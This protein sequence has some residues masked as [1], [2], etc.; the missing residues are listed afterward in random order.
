MSSLAYLPSSPTL[1]NS[2]TRHTQMSSLLPA[3]TRPRDDLDSIYERYAQVA[4]LSKFAG[5]IGIAFSR[6]RS[7]GA[8]IRGT[9]GQS[10]GIVPWLRTLDAS[11]AAVNQGGRRKGA[12]CVY[13]E[14]WHPDVEEFLELR[15]NTGEDA[16]RTHNL[17]LANWIPDEFM[18]RVEADEDWSL[19]DP[20]E[21]PELP[22]LW[23]DDVRRGLPRGRGRGPRRPAGEGPR[24]LRPDDAHAGPDRQRLDDVQGRR[25]P[26]LQPDR[27]RPGNVVHLSNLCTEI[28]EVSSDGETA[29][30]NLG[31]INLAQHLARRTAID[32]DAAAR[33]G[34]HRGAAAST[35]SSTSTT[36]RAREAA[37]S[38]PRWRPV[39]LGLMGLQDVFFALR[40]PFDSAGGARAVHPD[41]RGDLPDRAGGVGRPGR[42]STAPHPAFAETRAAARASCSPT[43]GA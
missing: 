41:R 35:G 7:R 5:G 18:R 4:K 1:F 43:C 8:L 9:N 16:R 22:D 2:G 31:S 25:Q 12:A 23:G 13:L 15:D 30:C 28:I 32:W 24:P 36:T 19:I 10:N 14:P 29:V 40:L 20:N 11:V 26:H 6:V 27:A 33:D 42:A 37:A 34:A 21:V 3:S 38:N 39:G 17:N